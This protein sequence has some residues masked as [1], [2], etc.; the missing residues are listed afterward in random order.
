MPIV[1]PDKILGEQRLGTSVPT[2]TRQVLT[3]QFAQTFE[4]NPINIPFVSSSASAR[5]FELRE[6]E[7]TG[8]KLDA[9]TARGRLKDA[10]LEADLKVNDAGITEAAL[11]TLMDRKRT[12]LRR[13]EVFQRSEGGARLMGARLAVSIAT[14]LADPISMGL[15]FVPYVGQVRY[16]RWLAT[17]GSRAARVG[18]RAGVGAIEGAVGTAITEPFIY[19]MRSQEQADYDAADSLLNVTLG[20]IAGAGLHATVGSA[21]ELFTRTREVRGTPDAAIKAPDLAART[22]EP[23]I[24][25]PIKIEGET[26]QRID[27]LPVEVQHAVLRAAVG[28]AVE[29][30]AIDIER[31][32]STV[33]STSLETRLR[34]DPALRDALAG[35]RTE[36]GWAEEGGALVRDPNTDQVTGRTS[37]VPRAEWWP[38]RPKGLTEDQ[39]LRTIDK[40]MAGEKLGIR[41]RRMVEFMRDVHDERTQLAPYL[42]NERELDVEGLRGIDDQ[43]ET[44]LI[45]RA[46]EIDEGAVERLAIQ[47][48]DDTDGFLRSVRDFLKDATAPAR[49][50]RSP[51]AAQSVNP[52][53][54]D[55]KSAQ[56]SAEEILSREPEI[57][58]SK[59][60]SEARLELA[61]QEAQLAISDAKASAKRLGAEYTEDALDEQL[62][63]ADRWAQIAELATVCLTR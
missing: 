30:R 7:R 33:D 50:A 47:H 53:E 42:P 13:Q 6:D 21:G 12:E 59:S 43:H 52:D 49:G 5:F 34:T 46:V 56:D 38:E 40:A 10:G 44:A 54:A 24:R 19:G 8:P 48:G 31:I 36:T 62:K 32:V 22:P 63:K 25:E 9:T 14:T 60:E 11:T 23:A 58:A 4:E 41:E 55:F 28:Q 51:E 18:V 27:A 45:A 39:I 1:Y 2:S 61:E 29:G 35:M 37:W 15:N 26:A 17:A 16:A 57:P 20:G 3:E